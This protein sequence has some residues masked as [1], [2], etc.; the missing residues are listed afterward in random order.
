MGTSTIFQTGRDLAI[1][2]TAAILGSR[3]IAIIEF[4]RA[5]LMHGLAP[6]KARESGGRATLLVLDSVLEEASECICD[7][8][9]R[10]QHEHRALKGHGDVG[11]LRFF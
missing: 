9:Q 1:G 6:L 4:R 3:R 10:G 7:E 8:E 11:V 2:R 5:V